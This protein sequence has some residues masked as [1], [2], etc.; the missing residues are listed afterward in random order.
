MNKKLEGYVE[1]STI[2][3]FYTSLPVVIPGTCCHFQ[4]DEY[5]RLGES[6]SWDKAFFPDDVM[7][8]LRHLSLS[9][10]TP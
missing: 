5:H 3:G 2:I 10:R 6:F 9:I 4:R 7:N 1:K 8:V